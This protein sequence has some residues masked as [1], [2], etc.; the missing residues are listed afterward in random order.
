MK[1]RISISGD[2]GGWNGG[3]ITYH[4]WTLSEHK[5]CFKFCK[6]LFTFSL[7]M[8]LECNAPG[9]TTERLDSL[10]VVSFLVGLNS[11]FPPSSTVMLLK[12]PL[13]KHSFELTSLWFPFLP[14]LCPS[15]LVC[16]GRPKFQ[17]LSTYLHDTV[18]SSASFSA[19]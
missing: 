2:A 16:I 4:N 15:S 3:N 8:L 6:D 9:V 7:P 19:S 18:K 5:T 12:A 14:D 13:N 1:S 11:H 10:S 17:C